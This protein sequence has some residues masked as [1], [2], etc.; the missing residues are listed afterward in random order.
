MLRVSPLG[1]GNVNDT[2]LVETQAGSVVLQ[3]LNT[4]VFPCPEQVMRN[5]QTVEAHIQRKE[6]SPGVSRW[7]HPRLVTPADG[8]DEPWYCCAEG[9]IWRCMS[10]I[11]NARSVDRIE[12]TEQAYQLGLGLGRFHHLISDLPPGEL[13]DTLEGLSLIHI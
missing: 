9:G 5:L 12:D 6:P 13:H 1:S 10:F 7:E 11:E 3:R 2:F 4:A 8:R